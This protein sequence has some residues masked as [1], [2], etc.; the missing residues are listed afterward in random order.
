MAG[1]RELKKLIFDFAAISKETKTELRRG[2]R[3]IATP[4]LHKVKR[5]ASERSTRI[6]PA[7][8]LRTSFTKRD[9][10]MRIVTNKQRAPHARPFEHGGRP[11]YF[12]HPL[13]AD[14]S[15]PR[16]TWKWYKQRAHPYMLPT[17]QDDIEEIGGRMLDLIIELANKHGFHRK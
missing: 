12:R 13:F 17:A 8:S 5:K 7:T 3:K 9:A 1:N 11:G 14:S 2:M 6:G 16:S 4:T 10:G 15:K